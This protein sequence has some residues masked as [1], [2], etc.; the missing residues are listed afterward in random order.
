MKIKY[1]YNPPKEMSQLPPGVRK[2]LYLLKTNKT[3]GKK[4][5]TRNIFL[6]I[7]NFLLVKAKTKNNKKIRAKLPNIENLERNRILFSL[8]VIHCRKSLKTQKI[9][10]KINKNKFLLMD[11]LL[12]DKKIKMPKSNRTIIIGTWI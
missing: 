4:G 1:A 6:L 7:D 8:K 3:I 9:K 11:F 2:E 12:S 10:N 5:S